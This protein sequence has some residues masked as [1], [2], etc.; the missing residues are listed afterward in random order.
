MGQ[1][2]ARSRFDTGVSLRIG[3]R[4]EGASK[5]GIAVVESMILQRLA[6]GGMAAPPLK[7]AQVSGARGLAVRT[8]TAL[9]R[10]FFGS[11]TSQVQAIARQTAARPAVRIG[12]AAGLVV[13]AERAIEATTG[14]SPARMIFDMTRGR[15]RDIFDTGTRQP[16]TRNGT[17]RGAKMAG[18]QGAALSHVVVNQWQTF[19]GG[20]VFT[21]FADGHIEVPKKNG[22]IRHYRPYRPVVIP[23]KWNARSMSRVATALKRQ[24]KTATKILQLTG[25][26]PKR[27]VRVGATATTHRSI[28]V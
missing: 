9:A 18:Q 6:P 3:L 19:P 7:I 10:R 17:S 16:A 28:D 20:P 22:T 15:G 26:V 27:T 4:A 21:R 8:T 13:G 11:R 1:R 5:R 2:P 14:R 25:G 23:R 12:A 24:R